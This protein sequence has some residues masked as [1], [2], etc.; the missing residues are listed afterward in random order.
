MSNVQFEQI[1]IVMFLVG[2]AGMLGIT[3]KAIYGAF[4]IDELIIF[5]CWIIAAIGIV[6]A[7]IVAGQ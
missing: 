2:L 3:G 5:V 7:S 1:G 4:G 6:L